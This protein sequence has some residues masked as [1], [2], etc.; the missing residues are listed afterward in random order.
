MSGHLA[1]AGLD[2]QEQEPPARDNPLLGLANVVL[3]PHISAG[4]RD[5]FQQKMQAIFE[6]LRAFYAGRPVRALGR[7]SWRGP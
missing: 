6:N 1:G 5:A 4:T 7:A 3:T 2:V